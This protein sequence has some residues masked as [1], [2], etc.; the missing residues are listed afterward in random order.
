MSE[1]KFSKRMRNELA[2]WFD[3]HRVES[4]ATSPGIPDIH[5]LFV[6]GGASGWAETKFVSKEPKKVAYQPQQAPWLV[7]YAKKG[8]VCCT[9]IYVAE[10]DC[11]IHVPGKESIVAEKDLSR[12]LGARRIALREEDA[13]KRLAKLILGSQTAK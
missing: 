4:H 13:W 3:F 2:S 1:S 12:C 5:W 11:V 9:L 6:G 7:S 10:S 8:G